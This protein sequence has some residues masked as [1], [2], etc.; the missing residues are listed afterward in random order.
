MKTQKIK[1]TVQPL[2]LL[3]VLALL[4]VC[5]H[6]LAFAQEATAGEAPI[7]PLPEGHMSP[8]EFIFNTIQFL[9]MAMI[10][11]FLMVINPSKSRDEAHATFIEGLKK[12]DDVVT[13]GGLIGKVAAIKKNQISVE[14]ANNVKVLVE[15]SHLRPR[16][17][18]ASPDSI[19]S[20]KQVI[21]SKKASKKS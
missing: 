14:L 20:G 3:V 12:N 5:T 8:K 21:N 11:Y 2:V 9:C 18:S 13:S 6:E 10:V 7:G 15:P 1:K 4:I 19:E 16:K 17:S